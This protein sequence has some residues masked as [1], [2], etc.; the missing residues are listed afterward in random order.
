MK[1]KRNNKGFSLVEL[2]VVMAIMAILAVTLAPR[3]IQY[4]DKARQAN[5]R[6]LM[7]NMYTTVQYALLD[8]L[9]Y[10][11]ATNAALDADTA[12]VGTQIKLFGGKDGDNIDD[13]ATTPVLSTDDIYD[14]TDAGKTWTISPDMATN[15]F[16]AEL[17]GVIGNFKLQSNKVSTTPQITISIT[18]YNKFTIEL[19]YIS[20]DGKIDYTLNSSSAS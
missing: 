1:K 10:T 19:D 15:A 9:T 6:E 12:T 20:T 11:A 7:N 8:N 16:V 5:D 14:V 18:D 3:L 17:Q 13:G 2:I 4:V